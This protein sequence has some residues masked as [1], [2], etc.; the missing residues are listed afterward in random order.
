MMTKSPQVQVVGAYKVTV[1]DALICDALDTKY[2]L[3]HFTEQQRREALPAVVSEM[4]S[5]VL[6]EVIIEGTDDRYSAD[7]FSQPDCDQAAYMETY[8]S[9]DGTSVVSEYSRPSGDF[10]RV[11]F[12]L[13]HFDAVRPL[14]TSYGEAS[15][16]T[17]AEMPER[18]SR[19]IRYEPVD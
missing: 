6:V 7:D 4:S 14:K 3:T 9:R 12:F 2:P 10:L 18:L 19:I 15:V 11:V 16:P 13:H 1:D 5:A 17:P 8:L